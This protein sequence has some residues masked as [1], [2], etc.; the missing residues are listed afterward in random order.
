MNDP[1]FTKFSDLWKVA[2]V[3]KGSGP[4]AASRRT[5]AASA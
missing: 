1:K 2:I 4:R 3:P 5:W